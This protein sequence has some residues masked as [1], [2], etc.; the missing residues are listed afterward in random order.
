MYNGN[1]FEEIVAA[2]NDEKQVKSM[3]LDRP[4]LETLIEI[5]NAVIEA[6]NEVARD[7]WQLR[8]GWFVIQVTP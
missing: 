8:K 1:P 4:R 7:Y 6:K 2:L 3:T 5:N